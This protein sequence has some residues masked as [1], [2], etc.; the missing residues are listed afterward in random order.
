MSGCPTLRGTKC[1]DH[2]RKACATQSAD[3]GR[4]P[5]AAWGPESDAA[6]SWGTLPLRQFQRNPCLSGAQLRVHSTTAWRGPQQL[7]SLRE[8]APHI[9]LR[10]GEG[11]PD[12]NAVVTLRGEID[13]YTS[14]CLQGALIDVINGGHV[15]LIVDLQFVA[16]LDSTGL[17]VLVGA[18]K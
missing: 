13:V 15:R 8:N 6:I 12:D 4:G 17:G 11:V 9:T 14:P 1:A 16:F 3:N 7:T 2:R 10:R 18:F 5:I